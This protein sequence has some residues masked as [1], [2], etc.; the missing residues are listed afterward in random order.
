MV[1]N[2]RVSTH[3]PLAGSD[4]SLLKTLLAVPGF[5]PR[6]PCGERPGF[7]GCH[8]SANGFQPTLPLR[9]ATSRLGSPAV[10]HRRFN[11]RSPCGE[12]LQGLFHR[13]RLQAVS[14]HAPLAGSDVSRRVVLRGCL[15]STHAPLAGSDTITSNAIYNDV[16]FQPTLPLRGATVPRERRPGVLRRFNPR[17]PCGER[18]VREGRRHQ[19]HQFQPTLP[20][21]GATKPSASFFVRYE[22]QPTL[23]LRGATSCSQMPSA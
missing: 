23:P 20:L 19:A 8:N 21:R 9:G 11:P 1:N 14:T 18:H 22:F 15:V 12:R 5:N 7:D 3:A 10:G 6:S 4:S 17:S 2:F 16:V 13:S